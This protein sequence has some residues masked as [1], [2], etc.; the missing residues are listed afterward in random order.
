[1]M[2]E[3]SYIKQ[4]VEMFRESSLVTY[5]DEVIDFQ[6]GT[7]STVDF[8]FAKIW[9]L[10]GKFEQEPSRLHFMHVHPKG[11]LRYSDL[12]WEVMV[13]YKMA[14]GFSFF[15]SIICFE[16]DDVHSL[17]CDYKTYFPCMGSINE[18]APNGIEIDDKSLQ[19]LK[20][21]SYGGFE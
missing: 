18:Y 15:F 19:I 10:R 3:G 11:F 4:G 1:M 2:R 5:F 14:F 13:G 12:D 16:D 8:D 9:A 6:V 20:I 7:P 21:L 17:K